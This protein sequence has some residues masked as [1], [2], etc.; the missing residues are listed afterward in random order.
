M[1]NSNNNNNNNGQDLTSEV[2]SGHQPSALDGP[3]RALMELQNKNLIE[4]V[5][6]IK[7]T[8]PDA[9][10]NKTVQLP[11]FNP[12]KSGAN[13]SSWCT[14][15]EV[16]LQENT[17][18]SSALVMAL[19]SA[20]EG[21]ASQWLSQVCYAEITW[22]EFK[23][24]F[25][26]RFDTIETPAAMFLNMLS[27]RP[28]DGE[29][30]AVHASRMVT[31]L[32]TKWRQMDN[33]EIAVSVTLALLASF[34]HRLQRLSFTSNVRTRVDLQ[35]ELKAFTFIKRKSGAMEHQA[36]TY[37]KRQ[38]QSPMECHFCGKVGHKMA[39][40]RFRKQ[41]NQFATDK[42]QHGRHDV[43]HRGK[44]NLTCYKCGELGHISTQCTKKEVD[45]NKAFNREKRVEQCS[46]AVPKGCLNHRGQI[47]E[48]T[49]D[50]GSECSLIKEKLSTKF[51]G[52]RFNNIVMLKGIG[53]NGICSTVQILSN[54]KIDDYC[55]EILFHVIGDDDMQNDIVIGREILNQ[56]LDIVISSNQFRIS[57]TKVV[58]LCT[59]NEPADIDTE[60]EGQDKIKLHSLLAKYSNS[61]ITGIPSTK[62]RIGEM[63]IR[64]IDPTKTVQRRPY[65]LSPCERDLVRDKI[66]E[67]LKCN[68]IRPSCSPYASPILLVKKKMVRTDFVLTLES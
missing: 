64:L 28:T 58:N 36:E 56:G 14:T 37:S 24:L 31:E 61:F 53:S 11:K 48:I 29:S 17:L 7:T 23:E 9:G 35:S 6:A 5:K 18:R 22:P 38:K 67:L 66:N 8:V 1:E 50:S 10:Q 60:L 20:L 57:K 62:V 65:R 46:V 30:L 19:S 27:N 40:C 52:K 34:D 32:T 63:K 25:I 15:V 26:Q 16:I 21:S 44:S 4:L 51:S 55:I 59:G 49:F 12:D 43:H 13:A 41:Q 33:E 54:V 42:T 45:R 68:I 2:G 3:W 39:E 47:F